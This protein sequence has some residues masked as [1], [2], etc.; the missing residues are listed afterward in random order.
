[1]IE[2]FSYI[3]E[4]AVE[5][6]GG[7]DE[8][9]SL[10]PKTLSQKQLQKLPDRDYLAEMTKKIFQSGFIWRVVESKWAGF[11]EIFWKFAP[12]KLVFA[13]D[14]QIDN[15]AQNKKIIR[16][17]IKVKAV[18]DNA[19][20]VKEE[21]DK[22]DGFG[23]FIAEWPETEITQLWLYLKKHGSRLGGNTGPYFLRTVGKDTFLLT[24]DVDYY[25]I[26]HGIVDRHP[27][28]QRDLKIVQSTFN[29][30]Q[31]QSGRTM[32]EISRIIACSVKS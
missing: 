23:Q 3:Y 22:H 32:S 16:N 1:M 11:E 19:Y 18:R 6:K 8:L 30:W 12:E 4:R 15:M 10:L 14:E 9:S 27:N 2:R 26:E 13:S 20:F 7:E 5:R 21:S 28:S 17:Y 29:E 31:Q 24:R 25:L